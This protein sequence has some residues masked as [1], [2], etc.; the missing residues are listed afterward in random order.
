MKLGD[1][2]KVAVTI[3]IIRILSHLQ[4]LSLYAAM[5]GFVIKDLLTTEMYPVLET[6]VNNFFLIRYD[7]TR[8]VLSL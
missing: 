8:L 6:T 3:A 2:S 7:S 5:G 1:F 4:Y